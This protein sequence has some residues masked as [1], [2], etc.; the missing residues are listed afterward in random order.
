[1]IIAEEAEV[2]EIGTGTEI[3]IGIGI[4]TGTAIE[5]ETEIETGNEIAVVIVIGAICDKTNPIEDEIF[6]S[7][8]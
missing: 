8:P 4:E 7:F 1:M 5:I 2:Q 3:E 6:L